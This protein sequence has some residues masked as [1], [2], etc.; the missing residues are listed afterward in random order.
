[1]TTREE[2]IAFRERAKLLASSE[3]GYEIY[4]G[5]IYEAK[6]IMGNTN[7]VIAF[8][9]MD[10]HMFYGQGD[11]VKKVPLEHF[12]RAIESGDLQLKYIDEVDV[13]RIAMCQI[14]LDAIAN[15]RTF[16]QAVDMQLDQAERIFNGGHYG[17]ED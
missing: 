6:T 1:M 7:Y 2:A 16:E 11:K 17:I 10:D 8:R 9:I 4:A 13:E 5:D 15:R 12:L 14:C 3:A